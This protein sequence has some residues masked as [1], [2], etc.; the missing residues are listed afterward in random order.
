M[1]ALSA[2]S[3]MLHRDSGQILSGGVVASDIIYRMA[4][5]KYTAAGDV[6]PCAAESGAV[7]AGVATEYKDNSAG[8]AGAVEVQFYTRGVFQMSFA[9]TLTKANLGDKVYASTDADVST[10][11]G[12]NEQF[13]GRIVGP[14]VSANL[15][16][17]DIAVACAN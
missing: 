5:L 11:Q 13:V 6:A 14:F 8:A 17:V 12:T 9:Q 1:A 15:A 10:T 16:W 2:N 4:L 3:E 7:F